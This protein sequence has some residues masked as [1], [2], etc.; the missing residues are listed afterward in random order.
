MKII[1]VYNIINEYAPFEL[2]SIYTEKTGAYDNSG[3][4]VEKAGEIK[5]VCFA[6]DLTARSLDFC[7]SNGCDVMVTHHPAIFEPIKAVKG[8]VLK[9]AQSGVGVISCH[10]NL[11]FCKNGVDETFAKK[12][13]AKKTNVIEKIGAGGYGR[14]FDVDVTLEEFRQNAERDL[15]TKTFTFGDTTRRIKKVASFCGAGLDECAIDSVKADLYCSADI[16]HHVLNYAL[17][18]G[19]AVMQFTHYASEIWGIIELYEHFLNLPKIKEQNIKICFFD[20]ENY[21]Q[22]SNKE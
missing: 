17:D 13:G 2:S 19:A 20:D 7:L 5:G 14:S 6:L 1:D 9:C 8:N 3:M 10:L 15:N 12:L 21:F 22:P 16:K 4:I 18:K 11:D